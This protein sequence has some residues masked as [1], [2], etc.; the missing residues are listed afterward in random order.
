MITVLYDG[1]LRR[2]ELVKLT[3]ED[4]DR[5]SRTLRF[6]GKRNKERKACLSEPAMA[7]L[8]CWL[9]LRGQNPGALF[10]PIEKAGRMVNRHLAPASVRLMLLKRAREAGIKPCTPHDLRRTGI[11]DM[12]DIPTV[13]AFAVSAQAGHTDP[14]TTTRYDRRGDRAKMKAAEGLHIPWERPDWVDEFLG[15]RK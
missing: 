15:G 14:G 5:G 13:D 3:L 6:V 2:H 1:L 10:W 11:S 4:C 12:L 8:E 9:D 7:P